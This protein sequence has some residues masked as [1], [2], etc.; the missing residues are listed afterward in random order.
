MPFPGPIHHNVSSNPAHDHPFDRSQP[1]PLTQFGTQPPVTD[2]PHHKSLHPRRPVCPEAHHASQSFEVFPLVH[3]F[4][5]ATFVPREDAKGRVPWPPDPR[6]FPSS[7][8]H[9]YQFHSG[10]PSLISTSLVGVPRTGTGV[11]K[12][13]FVAGNKHIICHFCDFTNTSCYSIYI[14]CIF[15]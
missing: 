4:N 8:H 6:S 14:F 15:Y 10:A 1:S 3:K 12:P 13:M 7:D 11:R 9:G 5:F 2:R